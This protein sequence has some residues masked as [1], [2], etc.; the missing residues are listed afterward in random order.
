MVRYEIAMPVS[1]PRRPSATLSILNRRVPGAEVYLFRPDPAVPGSDRYPLRAARFVCPPEAALE[2]GPIALY[3]RGSYVGDALVDRLHAG[4]ISLVP[5]ALDSS[6]VVTVDAGD[7]DVPLRLVKIDRGVMTVE[8]R[9][10]HR[11][12]YQV[13]TGKLPP[14]RIFV[15]HPIR[16]GYTI[17]RLP[18]GTEVGSEAHL[19]PVALQ[20]NASA[21]LVVEEERPARREVRLLD[22]PGVD[23]GL[24]LAGTDIPEPLAARVR[25]VAKLRSELAEKETAEGEVRERL[26]GSSQRSSE[27]RESLVAIEKNARAE[28]LRRELTGRLTEAVRVNEDLSKKLAQLGADRAEKRAQLQAALQD[29]HVDEGG[30]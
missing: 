13:A 27:L 10:L 8:D 22:G 15:R 18:E 11:T 21:L 4:E 19:M 17:A 24:Y 2:P 5:F 25:E 28:K 7:F 16:E 12:R 1:I 14:R 6:T 29:L 20:P 9:R 3:A 26:E 30:L 23:V